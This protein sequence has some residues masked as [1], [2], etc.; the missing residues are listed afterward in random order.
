MRQ[1]DATVL[2]RHMLDHAKEPVDLLFGKEKADLAS[3]RVLE[4]ALVRLIEI[5]GEAANRIT[6]KDQSRYPSIPWKAIIGMRNRLV[7]GYDAI[8][9]DVLWDT[10][11]V[12]LPQLI[13]ELERTLE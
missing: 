6:A 3:N 10:I 8:D 5:V 12:D 2:L 13:E 4:L 11:K 7:H 1:H 9:L